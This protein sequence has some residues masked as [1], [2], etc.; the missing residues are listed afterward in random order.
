ME[1]NEK[2]WQTKVPS[3]YYEAFFKLRAEA[4]TRVK[5]AKAEV[6]VECIGIIGHSADESLHPSHLIK[7]IQDAADKAKNEI[8]L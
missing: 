1:P 2:D 7:A 5:K 6:Y 4:D 3:E 8:C